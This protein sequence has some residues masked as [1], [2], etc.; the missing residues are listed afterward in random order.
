MIRRD[1]KATHEVREAAL[2][3]T[4]EHGPAVLPHDDHLL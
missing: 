4:R 3:T 2:V 1:L